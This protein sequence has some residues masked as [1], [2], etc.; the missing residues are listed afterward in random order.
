MD[1]TVCSREAERDYTWDNTHASH[2]VAESAQGI[3]APAFEGALTTSRFVALMRCPSSQASVM[4]G[5]S[6]ATTRKDFRN[7]SIHTMAFLRAETSE[8][9]NLLA[10]FF[11]ECLRKPDT[12]TLCNADG[13][14]AKA[15]E[16]LYQTKTIDEFIGFCK[17]LP[18]LDGAG[19]LFPR[20]RAIPRDNSIADRR[21]VADALPSLLVRVSEP[22]LVV[23]TDR[24]PTDVLGSLDSMFDH[25]TVRIFSKATTAP[26]ELPEP[27]SQKYFW[28]AAIGVVIILAAA[29]GSCS[30][31]CKKGEGG[32]TGGNGADVRNDASSSERAPVG[33]VQR[34]GINVPQKTQAE[35]VTNVTAPL[36]MQSKK[37]TK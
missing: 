9:S 35:S 31:G 30:R 8:E 17:G 6:V 7:R 26:E 10:A 21:K 22:F 29:I 18:K 4:L 13:P 5:V 28:A 16:S 12:E 32:G 24:T 19:V 27:A 1:W 14:L 20:R 2:S 36:S 33:L 15:V 3:F 37:E 34:V 25:A 23:L 11:A